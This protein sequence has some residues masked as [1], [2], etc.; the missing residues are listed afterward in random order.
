MYDTIEIIKNDEIVI[1]RGRGRPKLEHKEGIVKE[2]K[3]LGRPRIE[4]PCKSGHP[5]DPEYYKKYYEKNLAK[6][7]IMCPCCGMET[8]KYNLRNHIK[9]KYCHKL[10][11]FK[12]ELMNNIQHLI[13]K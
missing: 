4:N 12:S 10:I 5:K 11:E 3:P 8:H 1:K 6:N 2:K 7:V 9:S 13:T